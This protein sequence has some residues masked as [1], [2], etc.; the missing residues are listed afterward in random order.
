[1][2]KGYGCKC[3]WKILILFFFFRKSWWLEESFYCATERTVFRRLWQEDE[4]HWSS[5]SD[6]SVIL[7]LTS[8]TGKRI[9]I[10]RHT[11][12]FIW[13]IWIQP[14]N[15]AEI[16]DQQFNGKSKHKTNTVLSLNDYCLLRTWWLYFLGHRMLCG[17]N[18]PVQMAWQ[19]Q[20]WKT[21]IGSTAKVQLE[22]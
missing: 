6:S 2:S 7:R 5:V 10:T 18:L 13:F 11:F 15:A 1:M 12:S 19:R 17:T 4:G 16:H 21:E 14:W 8:S 20:S 22:C 9:N 3:S